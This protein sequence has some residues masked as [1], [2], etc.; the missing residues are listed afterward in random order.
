MKIKFTLRFHLITLRM[1]KI[2]LK[3]DPA[4]PLLRI[5]LNVTSSY[6]KDSCSAVL[7][8]FIIL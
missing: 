6:H 2:N 7:I 5:F 4:I 1:A 3:N 8:A